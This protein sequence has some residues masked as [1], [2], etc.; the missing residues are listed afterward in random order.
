MKGKIIILMK[1]ELE[2]KIHEIARNGLAK[3][4]WTTL[5]EVKKSYDRIETEAVLMDTLTAFTPYRK[6]QF[7]KAARW[8]AERG[9]TVYI[10]ARPKDKWLLKA[11]E[12][13]QSTL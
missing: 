9:K 11:F 10:A 1:D 6:K 13:E 4:F 2:K 12:Q 8:L 7:I 3:I 5:A